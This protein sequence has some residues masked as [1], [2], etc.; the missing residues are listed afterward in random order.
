MTPRPSR[1]RRSAGAGVNVTHRGREYRG[2]RNAISRTAGLAVALA[3][4]TVSVVAPGCSDPLAEARALEHQ[5]DL[6][7]AVLLYQEALEDD[8]G[9]A[10][11]LEGMI[12]DLLLL[13]GFDEAL[14]FQERL[15]AADSEDAQARIELG[16]NY[17]NHQA[18]P[19]DAVGVFQEAAELEPSAK[20]LTFLAQAQ[21][22]AGEGHEAEEVLHQA[23]A[24]DPSYPYSYSVL[25]G[26]LKGQE[27]STEAEHVVEE[28]SLHGIEIADSR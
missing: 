4:I 21:I 23:I 13:G 1:G 27:R 20:N 14:P 11:A 25:I 12:V 7:G 24:V 26:L 18:R 19:L 6:T 10:D 9:N 16:F 3:C 28:A 15:V 22:V 17:L 2:W 5:G 8:P